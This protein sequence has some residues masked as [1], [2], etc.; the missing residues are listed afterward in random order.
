MPLFSN[1]E[2]GNVFLITDK[3]RDLGIFS[4]DIV[5]SESI[6]TEMLGR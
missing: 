5:Y 1:G 4:I 2:S 3:C 6:K